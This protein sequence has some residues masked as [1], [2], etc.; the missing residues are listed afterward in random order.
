VRIGLIA[1]L[2][3]VL[4]SVVGRTAL[5]DQ[6]EKTAITLWVRDTAQVPDDVLTGA[7]GDVTRI[8]REAGVET[9]WLSFE[10]LSA[11]SIAARRAA[12][13]LAI[14]SMEQAERID[15]AVTSGR[16]GLTARCAQG[17]G[18]VAYV[19][20]DRIQALTAASGLDRARV[21]AIAMAHEIGHLLLPYKA[22]SRTGVMRADWT[23]ADLQLAQR[24]LVFFTREQGELLRNR[25]SALRSRARAE[26]TAAHLR[27][28][29]A[30]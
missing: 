7:R 5:A 22:H 3:C 21:L 10:S 16:M 26:S 25:I 1:R 18:R 30:E 19:F 27:R 23:N 8:Y 29:R 2:L 20:Y 14:L 9:T 12:L 28:L 11:E 24:N 6:A 13:T 15:A 17:G 4:V